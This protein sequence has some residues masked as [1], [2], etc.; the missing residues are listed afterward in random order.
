MTNAPQLLECESR[1]RSAIGMGG[2]TPP[3]PVGWDEMVAA[4]ARILEASPFCETSP[5]I[6]EILAEEILMTALFLEYNRSQSK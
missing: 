2:I 6:A 1:D 5:T 4:G 3:L